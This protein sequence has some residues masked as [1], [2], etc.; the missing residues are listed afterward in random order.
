MRNP[1]VLDKKLAKNEKIGLAAQ[2]GKEVFEL[3]HQSGVCAEARQIALF[4]H[5]GAN[6]QQLFIVEL[7]VHENIFLDV[8]LLLCV[9]HL[10]ARINHERREI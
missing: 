5:L 3:L 7:G 6:E 4:C 9:N 1:A 2:L 10:G 8:E